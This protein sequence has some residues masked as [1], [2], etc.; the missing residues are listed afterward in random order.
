MG[1]FRPTSKVVLWIVLG[2]L[3]FA[4]GLRL[5][6]VQME[7]PGF[8]AAQSQQQLQATPVSPSST[9]LAPELEAL[10]APSVTP[11]EAFETPP[12]QAA[13]A[14]PEAVAPATSQAIV[15]SAPSAALSQS[16]P[17]PTQA[18]LAQAMETPPYEILWADPTNYGDRYS[19]DIDGNPVYQQPLIV[20]HETVYS[21][22]SAINFFRTP[23]PDESDQASY[24]TLIRLNGTVIY[25]VPPEKRAYGAGNS[26]FVGPNGPETVKTHQRY[27]P[28]VNNFAYHVSLETPYDGQDDE[29]EHSGYTEEQYRSLAWLIAQSTVPDYRITTHREV[30]RSESRIDPR[31]FDRQKFL[32]LLHQ[33]RGV[34]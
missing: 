24:H 17:A 7:R 22:D 6:Q 26:V 34:R 16:A 29:V 2:L 8:Q 20:L 30:D 10:A 32:T 9:P 23:H 18:Q 19:T 1:P 27:P 12:T 13:P 5:H 31:S 21:A 25:M 15:Q 14:S 3:A 4:V 28:S 33:L 11:M